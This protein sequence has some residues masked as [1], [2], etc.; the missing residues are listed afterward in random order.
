[1][2]PF[3]SALGFL[4]LMACISIGFS[5][6]WNS[7]LKSRQEA[8]N[9]VTL[10]NGPI[11]NRYDITKQYLTNAVIITNQSSSAVPLTVNTPSAKTDIDLLHEIANR[12]PDLLKAN[13]LL[14]LGTH[15]IG[16]VEEVRLGLLLYDFGTSLQSRV[17]A[18]NHSPE[19]PL[20]WPKQKEGKP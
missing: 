1:M 13:L 12:Q 19:T 9:L 11:T 15:L 14:V 7:E 17:G 20:E 6:F 16:G 10:T 5:V 8:T 2:K 18:S 3:Q 4:G